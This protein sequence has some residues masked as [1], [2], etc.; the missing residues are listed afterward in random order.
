MI[1]A[2]LNVRLTAGKMC[3]TQ[4]CDAYF[5]IY[6]THL[7]SS[8]KIEAASRRCINSTLS[9][10]PCCEVVIW[11]LWKHKNEILGGFFF[12]LLK[13]CSVIVTLKSLNSSTRHLV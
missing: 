6:A 13:T 5:I 10:S 12:V 9:L 11:F 2:L 8:L 3:D 7:A 4:M 1:C